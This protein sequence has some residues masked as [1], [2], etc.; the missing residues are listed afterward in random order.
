MVLGQQL[1]VNLVGLM[2]LL[3]SDRL[4]IAQSPPEPVSTPEQEVIESPEQPTEVPQVLTENLQNYTLPASF[5][6]QIPQDWSADGAEA[7]RRAVITN[8]SP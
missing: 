6:L 8:Y 3:G 5:S 2:L 1:M 7:E 4:A